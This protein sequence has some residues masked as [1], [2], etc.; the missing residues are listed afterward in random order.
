MDKA[1]VYATV[2]V[3]TNSQGRMYKM[4]YHLL[5]TRMA[6][7]KITSIDEDV[8]KMGRLYIALGNVKWCSCC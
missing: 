3:K 4:R 2:C 6:E 1:S 8:E 5:P 7:N